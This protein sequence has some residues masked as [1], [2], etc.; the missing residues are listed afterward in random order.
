M[1]NGHRIE[2]RKNMNF[3]VLVWFG[4]I[5]GSCRGK[6]PEKEEGIVHFISLSNILYY[7][8]CLMQNTLQTRYNALVGVHKSHA[9]YR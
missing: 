8:E 1:L 7:P 9:R 5:N 2:T 3:I 4:L 6:L